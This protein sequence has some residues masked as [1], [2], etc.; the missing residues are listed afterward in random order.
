MSNGQFHHPIYRSIMS[1]YRVAKRRK[2]PIRKRSRWSNENLIIIIIIR[3]YSFKDTQTSAY[4]SV[5]CPAAWYHQQFI[6]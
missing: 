4:T 3:I 5:S 6:P 1:C 2:L